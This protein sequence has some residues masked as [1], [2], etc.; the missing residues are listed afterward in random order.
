M[1]KAFVFIR[2]MVALAIN[3]LVWLLLTKLGVPLYISLPVLTLA[4]SFITSKITRETPKEL[5][6]YQRVDKYFTKGGLRDLL[7]IPVIFFAFIHDVA[8]W[9][10]WGTYQV[11][12]LLADTL[13]LIKELLFWVLHALIWFLNQLMPFWRIVYKLFLFYLIK[14]PWWIYRYSYRSIRKTYNW[15]IL[16]VSVPGSFLTLFIFYFFYFLGIILE[17]QGLFLIGIVLALLPLSWTFGEISSIRGQKLLF[18]TFREVRMQFR[19]GLETVRGLLFFITLFVVLVMIETS[20]TLLGWIPKTGIVFLGVSINL[21]FFINLIV[22]ALSVT[23]LFGS[24]V[25]PTYRLYNEFSETSIKNIVHFLGHIFRRSLQ[26][27]AGFIPSSFFALITAIPPLILIT[28]SLILTLQVKENVINLKID[29]LKHKE[30]VSRIEEHRTRKE[31]NHLQY[32]NQFPKQILQEM[33]H[34]RFLEEEVDEHK[35]IKERLKLERTS[36]KS[37]TE[38][39]LT[40]LQTAIKAEKQKDIIDP[41]RIK[42]LESNFNKKTNVLKRFEE[43]KDFEIEAADIDIEFAL[44]KYRQLPTVFF[45]SGFFLTVI[46]T[47]FFSF[48]FGYF[49][50]FFFKSYLFRNDDTAAEWRI[51]IQKEQQLDKNQP[52]LSTSLNILLLGALVYLAVRFFNPEEFI[53]RINNWF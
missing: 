34:R 29:Y 6:N 44:R 9:A 15:N 40:G 27:V 32:I 8:V 1:I 33:E 30:T 21:S 20:L 38:Q 48:V 23:I 43:T 17:I 53:A 51:F 39:E 5:F 50:N 12:L 3:V 2:K 16:K 25:L 11:F 26:Y 4:F 10:I 52:L 19:N 36:Y 41:V 31:I 14:W 49:G 28:L 42:Q 46:G 13:F 35:R 37:Q 24:F 45:L 7:R 47:L 18:T 22:I